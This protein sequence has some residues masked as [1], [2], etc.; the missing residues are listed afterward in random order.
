[1]NDDDA[2]SRTAR[3]QAAIVRT[4]ATEMGRE[5]QGTDA[6][7]GLRTQVIEE[8]ARLL[9]ATEGLPRS[10]S[11]PPPSNGESQQEGRPANGRRWP[12]VLIVDDDGPT[13]S[14]IAR[15]LAPE[16]DVVVASN[17]LEGLKA[18]SDSLFDAI[19]TDIGMPEMDGIQMVARIRQA[20]DPAV[21]VVF[22]TAEM[23][24]ERVAE[25]FFVGG[26]SYLVKPVDLD[27]LDRELRWLL[28]G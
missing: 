12:R 1:V 13:R 16:Y 4:L 22:L 6:V 18:A 20:R 11:S 15:G 14:A 17:G 8:A 25:G 3:A 26:T 7:E 10:S 2:A 5:E 9:R 19:V 21:P 23:A 28:P 27:Q 24:P